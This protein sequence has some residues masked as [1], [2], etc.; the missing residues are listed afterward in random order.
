MLPKN[1]LLAVTLALAPLQAALADG[2]PVSTN[3]AK[4]VLICRD[5]TAKSDT[6]F[7]SFSGSDSLDFE[8]SPTPEVT[9]TPEVEGGVTVTNGKRHILI[10][11]KFSPETMY[12]VK[13]DRKSLISADGTYPKRDV[14][15]QVRIPKSSPKLSFAA[16]GLYFPIHAGNFSIPVTASNVKKIDVELWRLYDVNLNLRDIASSYNVR[17]YGERLKEKT[18]AVPPAPGGKPVTFLLDLKGLIENRHPGV[19]AVEIK[20][21]ALTDDGS[22]WYN[23]WN[24][25]SSRYLVVTDLAC[26]AAR[27]ENDR[28]IDV[29]VH[30]I[31]SG[32]P[33]DGADVQVLSVKNQI[34]AQGPA[35]NG[36]ARLSLSGSHD[37]SMDRVDRIVI[38]HGDDATIHFLRDGSRF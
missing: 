18:L 9:V 31:S 34:V 16:N 32:K 24:R 27:D 14:F 22:D 37:Y 28:N 29:F 30:S 5:V 13:I 23:Y 10:S 6:I 36:L 11:G 15:L 12:T 7:L 8:N 38:R 2:V 3:E 4:A 26:S 35:K 17:E 21:S 19:Y 20:D 1:L 33:L 25:R